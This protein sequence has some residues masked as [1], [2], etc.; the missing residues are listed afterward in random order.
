ML[1]ALKLS[2]QEFLWGDQRK[3]AITVQYF[4]IVCSYKETSY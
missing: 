3:K 2:N 1:V 4:Y